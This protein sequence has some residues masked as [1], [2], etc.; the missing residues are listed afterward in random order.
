M[1]QICGMN[2][3]LPKWCSKIVRF[4]NIFFAPC[5]ASRPILP[6]V[7]RPMVHVQIE[8]REAG[9]E[10]VALGKR[11]PDR[12][13]LQLDGGVSRLGVGHESRAS[14]YHPPGFVGLLLLQQEPEAVKAA[15][16]RRQA[17]G[18]LGS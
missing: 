9:Q 1:H 10:Q 14:L 8:V 6:T 7:Q 4:K 16:V 18:R 17:V 15:R 13:E 5:R 12:G 11:S 2:I 3:F